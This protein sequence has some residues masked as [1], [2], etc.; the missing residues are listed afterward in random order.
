MLPMQCGLPLQAWRA[1]S[2][3]LLELAPYQRTGE[4]WTKLH[5]QV[6]SSGDWKTSGK[7]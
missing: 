4:I 6:D 7:L 2:V 1:W 5:G 3:S